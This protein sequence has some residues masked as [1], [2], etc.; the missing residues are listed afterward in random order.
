MP[1]AIGKR[2]VAI[3]IVIATALMI[4]L[5]TA[6]AQ[7]ANAIGARGKLLKMINNVRERNDLRELRID[8]SLSRDA[9]R[10]TRRMVEANEV[11]DPANLDT[12]LSDEPWERIG[13]SVSGCA[14]T[15]R[16]VHRAW[17]RHAA[18]RDIMLEPRLRRIGIG[19]IT[20]RSRNICGRG[21]I[22]ATELFY[23]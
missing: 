14:G 5:E 15:V 16:G 9:V 2:R 13:A 7:T 17:M 18:H 1:A 4:F 8:R 10:H 22:W 19:V 6:S 20:D 3:A 21:S 11:F 12:I 23:G